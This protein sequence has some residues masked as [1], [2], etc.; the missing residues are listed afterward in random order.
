[1]NAVGIRIIPILA[2]VSRLG[3]HENAYYRPRRQTCREMAKREKGVARGGGRG[4]G[5]DG[6]LQR[7]GREGGRGKGAGRGQRGLGVGVAVGET[8]DMREG[9]RYD[10]E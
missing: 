8:G 4:V 7:I 10:D 9:E 1:M 2:Q 5:D 6:A 3:P